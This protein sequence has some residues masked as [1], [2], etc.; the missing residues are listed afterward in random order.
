[1]KQG[2]SMVMITP[3]VLPITLCEIGSALLD[4]LFTLPTWSTFSLHARVANFTLTFFAYLF[5][6]FPTH[7]PGAFFTHLCFA[8]GTDLF[9]AHSAYPLRTRLTSFLP[10]E[11]G[12]LMILVVMKMTFFE[13]ALV[14]LKLAVARV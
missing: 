3:S 2:T 9:L 7:S 8:G 12:M 13:T 14:R 6:T 11:L 5:R 4:H 1:M 10:A